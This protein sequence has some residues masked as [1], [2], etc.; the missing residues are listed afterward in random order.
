MKSS[1]ARE[2]K[3]VRETQRQLKKV[4][5]SQRNV[6]N[7]KARNGDLKRTIEIE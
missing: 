1:I 4:K 2:V 7:V 5:E 3:E 6:R